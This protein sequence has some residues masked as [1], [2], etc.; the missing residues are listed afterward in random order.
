MAAY[1]VAQDPETFEIG[2]AVIDPILVGIAIN[3]DNTELRD[4][5]QTAVD[6][7]Y[8][9]GT[10]MDILEKWEL[11]DFALPEDVGAT[12]MASPAES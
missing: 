10:M 5:V 3:K 2:D 9:D 4:Q 6:E 7:M 1:Y 8:A 12:P 11:P